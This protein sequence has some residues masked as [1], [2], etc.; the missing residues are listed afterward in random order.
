M[1]S[2]GRTCWAKENCWS[3]QIWWEDNS[4]VILRQ[5]VLGISIG[6]RPPGARIHDGGMI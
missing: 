4:M 5:K 6:R 3:V 1:Y 2:T